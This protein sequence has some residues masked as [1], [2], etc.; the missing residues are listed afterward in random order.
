[1]LDDIKNSETAI[2]WALAFAGALASTSFG[3]PVSR[4]AAWS[5]ICIGTVFAALVGPAIID[6]A[7]WK[8]PDFPGTMAVVSAAIFLLGTFSM[9]ILQACVKRIQSGKLPSEDSQNAS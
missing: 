2:R 7:V 9:V 4:K 6:L 5:N 8:F 1:M 3:E